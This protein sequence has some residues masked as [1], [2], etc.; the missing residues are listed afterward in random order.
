MLNKTFTLETAVSWRRDRRSLECADHG[1]AGR[2]L[3]APF[4]LE[5]GHSLEPRTQ[6][7]AKGRAFST[8]EGPPPSPQEG[9]VGY[10]YYMDI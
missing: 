7:Q 4:T 3:K 9:G 5:L 6:G 1:E 2:G 8:W 10:V